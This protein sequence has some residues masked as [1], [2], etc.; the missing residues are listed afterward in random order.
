MAAEAIMRPKP[1]MVQA[2]CGASRH[3][4]MGIAY[5]P[6]L[7]A[8][9][10]FL[11]GMDD[12]TLTEANAADYLRGMVDELIAAKAMDPWCGLCRSRRPGWLFEDRALLFDTLEEAQ[13]YLRA[14]EQEQRQA[15]QMWKASR[16]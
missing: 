5:K 10:A 9:Q 1:R 13:P 11:G 7:T 3:A 14:C 6:G 16:G 15:A 12:V 8:A 4:I 2:L